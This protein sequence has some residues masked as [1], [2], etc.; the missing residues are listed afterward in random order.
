MRKLLLLLA[1]T[2]SLSAQA[3]DPNLYAGLRWRLV[4]PFRGGKATSASG[5]PG[6]PAIY[7]FGTAGSGVWKTVDGGQV[8]N[9]VSDSVRLTGI[10]AVAV[11]PSRADTVYIGAS[12]GAAAG[13]YRSTDGGEHW[14][15]VGLQGHGVL[16]IVI[17]PHNPDVVMAA[18]G[19][20]GVVR[21]ADGGKTW[22]SVLPDEKTGGV[23][24]VFDPDDPRN[25]YAGTR[26]I[27]QGGR[28]GFGG[29]GGRG[30]PPVTTPA[31][32]SQIFRS[33]DEGLTWTKTGPEG[34][35]GGNFGTI[36]LAVAPGSRGQRV[37]DYVAQGMSAP[38]TAARTGR[39]PRTIR[40]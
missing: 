7:Y 37:Y 15:L 24:L 6:N 19:D 11:A 14:D 17:D 35:P 18:S 9:C 31:T 29:G 16:S 38:T 21:S 20:A 12:Q 5:V 30:A 1:T 23:W 32:D 8:W 36:S 2:L 13:L 34:L 10:G 26:A 25:V 39:A 28:G 4:G 27:T 3:V 40:D 22:K 33:A